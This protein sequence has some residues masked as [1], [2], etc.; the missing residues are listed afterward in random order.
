M[1]TIRDVARRAGVAISTVSAVVNRSAPTSAE[2]VARVEQAIAETGYLPQHAARTLRSGQSRLIGLIIPDITNPHFA[3]VARV[4]ENTCLAAGYMTFIYNTDEDADHEIQ[5]LKMMRMQ[6]VAGM[7]LIPTRSDAGHG[8]RLMAEIN[9]P[10]VLM[11]SN[12]VGT[13]FDIITLDETEAGEMAMSHLLELGHRQ[14]VVVAGRP[15]VSTNEERIE[16]CRR[17]LARRGLRLAR[18][19]VI[20]ANFNEEQAFAETRRIM[21]E[22]KRPTAIVSL[23]NL[24]TVGVMRALVADGIASPDEVAIVGIDDFAWAEIINPRPTTIAQPIVDMT[25]VAIT[26]LIDQIK[27]GA[28]PTGKRRCFEPRLII[29]EFERRGSK[30]GERRA[31]AVIRRALPGGERHRPQEDEHRRGRAGHYRV[32]RLSDRPLAGSTKTGRAAREPVELTCAPPSPGSRRSRRR[33][34]VALRQA[35]FLRCDQTW[36]AVTTNRPAAL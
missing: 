12:V 31:S 35:G 16:G 15:G 2:V 19:R 22:R 21:A 7:V 36:R 25:G 13:P 23:S 28:R 34:T 33:L 29:R 4:V 5:I 10:T 9:V 8:E 11:G 26:M 1:A 20:L 32:G 27:S 24:M 30:T 14:V 3:T 18:D 6:Q 17:A